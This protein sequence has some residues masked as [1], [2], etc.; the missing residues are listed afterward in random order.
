MNTEGRISLDAY[1]RY[2]WILIRVSLRSPPR[3]GKS[4]VVQVRMQP[5]P[6]LSIEI[7]VQKVYIWVII[8]YYSSKLHGQVG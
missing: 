7:D 4:S 5:V 3:F 1:D 2:C 6:L 8:H